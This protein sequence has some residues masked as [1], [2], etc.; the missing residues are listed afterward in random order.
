ML[1]F[2]QIIQA[3]TAEFTTQ[4]KPE[5]PAMLIKIMTSPFTRINLARLYIRGD[6]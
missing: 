6:R 1:G 3:E 4:T 5:Y 2:I